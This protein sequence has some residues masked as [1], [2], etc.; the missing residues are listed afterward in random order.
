[1][2]CGPDTQG[3]AIALVTL[4]CFAIGWNESIAFAFTSI[5][6]D[7]QHDIGVAAGLGGSIRSILSSV[8]TTIYQIVLTARLKK[9]IPALVPAALVKAGLPAAEVPSIIAALSVG[10]KTLE[11]IKGIA[12]AIIAVGFKA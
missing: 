10:T 12:P 6:I 7:N 8:V 3:T 2:T 9:T 5:C 11:A 1:V 4:C